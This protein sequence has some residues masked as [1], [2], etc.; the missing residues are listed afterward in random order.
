MLNKNKLYLACL[1]AVLTG[2]STSA[3]ANTQVGVVPVLGADS[4]NQTIGSVKGN[5]PTEL[6]LS[7]NGSQ[8]AQSQLAVKTDRAGKALVPPAWAQERYQ[9]LSSIQLRPFAANLFEGR[10]ASTFSDAVNGDY[11]IGAGDRIV[12]RIWGARSYDAVLVV[13]Q[14]G[15]IFI[16]EV[17]PVHL[18]GVSQNQLTA[19]VKKAL[20]QVFTQNIQ[21]YVNLQ[22][23]QP[24]AVYVAGFVNHPGR[25][26]GGS[27][28]SVMAFID[29]AGG[30]DSERGS[31]RQ[32]ELIRENQLIGQYDLYDFA[33]NGTVASP[34]LKSGDV[35]LI[36]EKGVSVAAFGHLR[37]QAFYEFANPEKAKGSELIKMAS[38]LEDVTHASVLGTRQSKPY[39]AYFSLDEFKNMVLADGDRVEFVSDK[40]GDTIMASVSG[41]INGASRYPVDK[42]V[43]LRDFLRQIEIDQDLASVQSIYVRRDSVAQAQKIVLQDSLRR[44]EQTALTA[45]SRTPEEASIRVQEAKLIQ[46][47]VARASKLEPDG[48]VVVSRGGA[49]QDILL[50]QGDEIVIPQ[51][52][53]VVQVTGEVVLT[54][55][56]AFDNKMTLDDYLSAAGGVSSRADSQNILVAKQN[57][58]VGLV[59]Q[60]GIEPGDRIIV[61]PKVDTKAMMMAK[62]LMQIIYQIA[63]ATKVAVDL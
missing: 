40:A 3:S 22:S 57:G 41:A 56:V 38:P 49:I 28:D 16:P 19:S 8:L 26:A 27:V 18:A 52:S 14:Q 54:K 62:D 33:L 25:Y 34:R 44:L 36:K 2:L 42:R 1:L 58:E 13:D 63:V 7:A 53:D 50:E 32:I 9:N 31:Y 21:I 29:R 59:G 48:V 61:L 12:V 47:F 5:D 4:Q 11:L 45:T 37:D 24:V 55:A 20:G 35:I 10:F 43:R 23:A 6:S 17:G 60:L 39:H 46:N 15:N 51:K 30:I